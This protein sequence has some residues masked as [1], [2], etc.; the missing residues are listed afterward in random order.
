MMLLN[1][2]MSIAPATSAHGQEP[3]TRPE[4]GRPAG[5][6]DESRCAENQLVTR[7]TTGY[8]RSKNNPASQLKG[9]GEQLN[10]SKA[11][12]SSAT[13]LLAV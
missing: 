13:A 10:P 12:C 11:R 9:G 3:S 4:G 8:K 2:P 6:E 5:Y 1:E 7:G